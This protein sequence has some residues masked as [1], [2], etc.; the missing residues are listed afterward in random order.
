MSPHLGKTLNKQMSI[1]ALASKAKCQCCPSTTGQQENESSRQ[2]SSENF[3]SVPDS[4]KRHRKGKGPQ[5]AVPPPPSLLEDSDESESSESDSDDSLDH[6]FDTTDN[7]GP[8]FTPLVTPLSSQ[9]PL[10]L[11]KQI[12]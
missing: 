1:T 10:K 2:P 4:A 9:V 3:N 11:R 5:V 7:E 12:H 8:K 6:I